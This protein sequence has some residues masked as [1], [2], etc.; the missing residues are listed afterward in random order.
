M[1]SNSVFKRLRNTDIFHD[2]INNRDGI[3]NKEELNQLYRYALSLSQHEDVACDLVQSALERYLKKSHS[4]CLDKPQRMP[5]KPLAY[6]KTMIRNLYFD[7]LRRDKVVPMVSLESED[8]AIIEPVEQLSME[9]LL[10]NQ[11]QVHQVIESLNSE[12]NELLYLWAVE[13]H[14][15]DE[16][17]GIYEKPRGTV[18][19]KLHRLKKRIRQALQ[20][21]TITASPGG[22]K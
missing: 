1:Q 20:P 8:V 10:I 22:V 4:E 15:V 16:I 12:E 19:S 17:A 9:Q 2:N 7:Q 13:E 21:E 11:Q 14:T 3:F 18:L 5:E 6:L